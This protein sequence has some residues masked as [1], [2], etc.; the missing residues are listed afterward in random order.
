VPC[1][2]SPIGNWLM[3]MAVF[4]DASW[5]V[6]G[7]WIPARANQIHYADQFGG[8]TVGA[9]IQNADAACSGIACGVWVVNF[10]L[11]SAASNNFPS[12]PSATSTYLDLRTQQSSSGIMHNAL[13]I[14]DGLYSSSW[15]KANSGGLGGTKLFVGMSPSSLVFPGN[16]ATLS[17]ILCPSGTVA[18]PPPTGNTGCGGL[19]AIA[20]TQGSSDYF[21]NATFTNPISVVGFESNVSVQGASSKFWDL[22]GITSGIFEGATFP[23][24][25]TAGRLIDVSSTGL[26]SFPSTFHAGKYIGIYGYVPGVAPG[27]NT[28]TGTVTVG[29]CSSPPCSVTW[30][31]GDEFYSNVSVTHPISLNGTPYPIGSISSPTSMTIGCGTGYNVCPS[32]GTYDYTIL[33]E[34]RAGE[35]YGNTAF[36]CNDPAISVNDACVQDPRGFHGIATVVNSN[37]NAYQKAY[38]ADVSSLESDGTYARK[39]FDVSGGRSPATSWGTYRI[40]D[41]AGSTVLFSVSE[42]FSGGPVVSTPGQLQST[43]PTGTP[44]LIVASTTNVANLNASSLNGATFAAPGSIGNTTPGTGTFATLTISNDAGTVTTAGTQVNAGTCQAQTALA[45]AGVTTSHAV[46]WSFAGVPPATWLTG[47]TVLPSVQSGQV[48][49]YLCN[50]T[51]ASIT[52]VAATLN[53]RVI[54]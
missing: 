7:G 42:P 25:T 26:G 18:A 17:N 40:M 41:H 45:L 2:A 27:N 12:S 29:S 38:M 39:S 14:T 54:R 15:L 48:T 22:Y 32:S 37:G 44:P 28:Y 5:N 53:V 23:T 31:S 3:Q 4:R 20:T 9:Q 52:P 19:T 46:A 16:S 21:T 33:G 51:A 1:P 34:Q 11:V 47:I 43:V 24:A 35:F 10:P 49:I 30:A 8:T 13:N 50:S 6:Q 36:M